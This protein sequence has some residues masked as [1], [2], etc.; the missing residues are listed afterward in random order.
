MTDTNKALVRKWLDELAR[1]EWNPGPLARLDKE[2]ICHGM[3]G[4]WTA[5]AGQAERRLR[6][7]LEPGV[8]APGGRQYC[9][10]AEGD[11]VAILGAGIGA[12]GR[13]AYYWL[14]VVR[15]LG[16]KVAETWVGGY[17]RGVDWGPVPAE[18]RCSELEEA[19]KRVLRRWWD[20]MYREYRFDE[21]M[22]ELAGPEYIRHEPTGSW[23][24]TIAEHLRRVKGL[25]PAGGTG[26]QQWASTE[27][28]AEGDLVAGWGTG[29]GSRVGVGEVYSL[30]Q[31]FRV[32]AGR[33]VETWFPG[34]VAGVDW[35][36]WSDSPPP[37]QT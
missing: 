14:Q 26:P 15:L 10:L 3:T 35:T 36:R 2:F 8:A 33:L 29:G 5:A 28:I 11:K 25:Y 19:N 21:L 7:E 32:A 12:E 18:P 4:T 34:Y 17:A 24:T 22:P 27:I 6:E 1:P 16:G 30:V 9:L 13:P 23:T 37:K 20:E 31:L